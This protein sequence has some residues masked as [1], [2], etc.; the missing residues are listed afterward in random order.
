MSKFIKKPI[1]VEAVQWFKAGDH[2]AV[3]FSGKDDTGREI[4]SIS[5]LEGRMMVS[6]GDWIITGV[7]GEH[8]AIKPQ[9]FAKSY[10]PVTE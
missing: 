2:P 9:I 3:Q 7:E 1:P 8:Y 5:T 10:D 6:P 4:H